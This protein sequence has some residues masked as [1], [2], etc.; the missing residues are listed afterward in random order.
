[1]DR[2]EVLRYTA[3]ATGA[4][5]LFPASSLVLTGCKTEKDLGKELSFF[6][7]EEFELIKRIVD[8]ILPKTDSPSASEVGVHHMID[9]MVG[10]SYSKDDRSKYRSGFDGMKKHLSEKGFEQAGDEQQ[11]EIL[12]QLNKKNN[13]GNMLTDAFLELRQQTISCYL[14]TEEIGTKYLKLSKGV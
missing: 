12:N 11:M 7:S 6:S 2:R 10:K 13:R 1:M 14:S 4:A 8:V 9:T 5:I 3:I